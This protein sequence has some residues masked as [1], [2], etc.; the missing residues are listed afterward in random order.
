[1]INIYHVNCIVLIV[2]AAWIA[3]TDFKY[4]IIPNTA[5]LILLVYGLIISYPDLVTPIKGIATGLILV[6]LVSLLG[7]IGG[8]DIKL[9]TVLGAW[10]GLQIIDVF[11]LSYI[12]GLGFAI[13]YY[14]KYRDFKHEVPFGPSIMLATLTVYMTDVSLIYRH[15]ELLL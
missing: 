8:G 3:I 2:I 1:M 5:N 11:L 15:I 10:F 4:K 7:P 6:L 14:V 13:V 12:V 9:M